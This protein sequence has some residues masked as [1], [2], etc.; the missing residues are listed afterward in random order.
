VDID[1][2]EVDLDLAECWALNSTTSR[3]IPA[4]LF[5]TPPTPNASSDFNA[6]TEL[7]PIF[8]EGLARQAVAG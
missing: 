4:L 1:T 2:P 3:A 8:G 5:L 6:A 7:S